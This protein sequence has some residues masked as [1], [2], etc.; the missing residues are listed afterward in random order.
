MCD[1]CVP[2]DIDDPREYLD[3][4][5]DSDMTS[6]SSNDD[7]SRALAATWLDGLDALIA[8]MAPDTDRDLRGAA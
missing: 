6:W 2:G 1:S 4:S 8:D 7:T 5:P 3:L